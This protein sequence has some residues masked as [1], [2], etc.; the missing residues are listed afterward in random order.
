[1]IGSQDKQLLI[2]RLEKAVDEARKEFYKLEQMKCQSSLMWEGVRLG[3][4]DAIQI[5]EG[6]VPKWLRGVFPHGIK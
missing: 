6:D 1:M 5:I 2:D 4:Q 3:L